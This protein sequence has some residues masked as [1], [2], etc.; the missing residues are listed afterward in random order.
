MVLI[1]VG[2]PVYDAHMKI[3]IGNLVCLGQGI[4]LVSLT[5]VS[6][7]RLFFTKACFALHV[8]EVF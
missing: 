6:I 2:N 7:W 1:F 8:S 5:A 3:E 4:Y